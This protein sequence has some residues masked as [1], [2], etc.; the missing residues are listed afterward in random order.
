[1]RRICNNPD[2]QRHSSLEGKIILDVNQEQ[3]PKS[4]TIYHNYNEIV[5][6]SS[7]FCVLCCTCVHYC[8]FYLILKETKRQS[9]AQSCTGSGRMTVLN[10]E[11]K[12]LGKDMEISNSIG[13]GFQE[14]ISKNGKDRIERRQ[15][16]LS[17]FI[18]YGRPLEISPAREFWATEENIFRVIIPSL[19]WDSKW[20]LT[21]FLI[22]YW[23]ILLW[24]DEL[25]LFLLV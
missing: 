23:L 7:A 3:R 14:M 19:V 24:G 22:R 6:L 21:R 18:Y 10:V 25:L 4:S 11:K 15:Y 12:T 20:L 8:Y 2:R 17:N 5:Y 16:E 9:L 13:R 1:M